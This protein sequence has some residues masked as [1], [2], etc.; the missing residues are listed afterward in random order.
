MRARTPGAVPYCSPA[1]PN[2]TMEAC[3]T[4]SRCSIRFCH[5]AGWC[6]RRLLIV[7][8]VG[9]CLVE[10]A[11]GSDA[12]AALRI[13][14]DEC[15]GCHKPGKAKGGLLLT[16]RE[17]ALA[18]GDNG[19]ALAP[20]KS[21]DSLLYQLCLKTGDPHMP[22]KKQLADADVTTIKSWIDRGAPW[23]ASVF[24]EPP[25]IE[26]VKLSAMP[27]SYQPVLALALSP[28]EHQLAVACANVIVLRDLSKPDR[29]VL[30]KLAG[31][32]EAIQ[33]L[34][35]TLDGKL[36][37]SGGFRHV[38]IWDVAATKEVG[39]VSEKMVGN[40]TALAIASDKRTLLAADGLPGIGG[41]IH[42]IDLAQRKVLGAWKAHEDVIYSLRFSPKGDML[43]SA[44]ADKLAKLWNAPDQKPVS[45]FEGHTNHVLAAVF[46][47][48]ASQ[49]AT[50]GADKEV[51]VWDAKSHEQ[52]ISLGDKKNVY[53][54]LAWTPDSKALIAITDKGGGSI[55]TDLKTHTG[56]ER[57]ETGKEQRL[58]S[59]DEMFYCLAVTAD[60]KTIFA[61]SDDG[62]VQVWDGGGKSAGR[63]EDEPA[64]RRMHHS[65]SRN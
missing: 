16:T 56:G 58:S 21:H 59:V 10:T 45:I 11:A 48:D 18:G 43:L 46:N 29:P 62:M 64:D 3:F 61:G 7:W 9:R 4:G 54:A 8:L 20:N 65:S 39:R 31:H 53:T 2:P 51:K 63:I 60:S 40:I 47:H 32:Q 5:L 15:L 19:P 57:S 1:H 52:I 25:K 34:A 33:S 14:R 50:A 26:P 24:D 28:D 55:F 6:S 13:L 27:E 41:F 17:K 30:A 42:R 49:I 23:D 35:W 22:P 37:V 12:A 44:A 38:R 36:L